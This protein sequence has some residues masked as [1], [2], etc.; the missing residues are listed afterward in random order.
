MEVALATLRIVN[1]VL[2]VQPPNRKVQTPP[3]IV[4]VRI[5][6]RP[7][8]LYLFVIYRRKL[9]TAYDGQ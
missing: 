7:Q 1:R 9:F 2:L 5:I 6:V 3:K 8:L 4:N